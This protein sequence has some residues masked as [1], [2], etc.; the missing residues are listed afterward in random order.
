MTITA[1]ADDL[2]VNFTQVVP[3]CPEVCVEAT[4]HMGRWILQQVDK[5]LILG[6]ENIIKSRLTIP[7]L[8]NNFTNFVKL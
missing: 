4:W 6:L 8:L 5:T 1:G 7:N 3:F 2:V